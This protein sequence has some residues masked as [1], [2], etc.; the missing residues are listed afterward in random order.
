MNITHCSTEE[1]ER[2]VCV[3]SDKAVVRCLM[4]LSLIKKGFALL[5]F[6]F[7]D[8][9]DDDACSLHA[10]KVQASSYIQRNNRI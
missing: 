4:K 1:V 3:L 7:N 2:R 5:T 9:D 6:H 8:D 10:A